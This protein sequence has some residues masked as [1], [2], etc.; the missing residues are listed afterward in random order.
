MI[1]PIRP[2]PPPLATVTEPEGFLTG[3]DKTTSAHPAQIRSSR[4]QNP[5]IPA[6]PILPDYHQKQEQSI[7]GKHAA[8]DA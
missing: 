8:S 4:S 6:I 7:E 1:R 5:L 2:C 3:G